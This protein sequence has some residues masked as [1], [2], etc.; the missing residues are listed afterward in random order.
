MVDTVV[1]EIELPSTPDW[2]QDVRACAISAYEAFLRHSWACHLVMAPPDGR[3]RIEGNPRLRYM[4]WLLRRLRVAGFS[5]ELTYRGYHALDSH[6]LGFTMWHVGHSGGGQEM[7]EQ[8]K[9]FLAKIVAQLTASGLPNLAEHAKH[10]L[11]APLHAVY[12]IH[13][14]HR[15]GS[16][17][18]IMFGKREIHRGKTMTEPVEDPADHRVPRADR[19]AHRDFGRTRQQGMVVVDEHRALAS[20]RNHHETG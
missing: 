18:V 13:V 5:E 3:V 11:D 19:A 1:N 4:E 9:D 6:I 2:E 7:T 20:H 15:Y 12:A 16:A 14:A 8:G 10:H 17:A